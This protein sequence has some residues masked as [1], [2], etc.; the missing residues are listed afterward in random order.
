MTNDSRELVYFNYHEFVAPGTP[1]FLFQE[2]QKEEP[3]SVNLVVNHF[4]NPYVPENSP[5]Y[6]RT[7]IVRIPRAYDIGPSLELIPLFSLYAPGKE[8]AALEESEDSSYGCID[9]YI[10]GT[11][12]MTQL[13]PQ[14]LS[15]SELHNIVAD[16]NSKISV[17]FPPSSWKSALINAL[18]FLSGSLLT[19]IMP[20]VFGNLDLEKDI[21][22]YVESINQKLRLRHS[23]LRLISPRENA[24]LSLDFQIPVGRSFVQPDP[25]P[26]PLAR[27]RLMARY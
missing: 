1:V 4:P 17:M 12:S 19:T 2:S 7:R 6:H 11:S 27:D 22:N 15:E 16:L 18:D 8:P 20:N 3:T 21:E 10:Y 5:L 25:S 9:G 23:D 13:V 26:A 14:W 24:M